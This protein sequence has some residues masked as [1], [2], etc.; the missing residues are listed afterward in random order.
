MSTLY[1]HIGGPKTGSTYLQSIFRTNREILLEHDIFYPDGKEKLSIGPTS[2]TSGNGGDI[3]KSEDNFD[4]AM[5][6]IEA[7]PGKSLF[8]SHEG[9]RKDFAT[10]DL[11]GLIPE[12]ARSKGF[13]HIKILFLVRNPV[14][15]AVS[16]WQQLVKNNGCHDELEDLVKNTP[17]MSNNYIF[18]RDI[19]KKLSKDDRFELSVFNYSRCSDNLSGLTMQWLGIPEEKI[20][21]PEATRINRSLTRAELVLQM[22]MNRILGGDAKILSKALTENITDIVTEK[23]SLSTEAQLVLWNRLKPAIIEA[24]KYLPSDHEIIFDQ[25]ETTSEIKD[26]YSFSGSQLELIGKVVAEEIRNLRYPYVPPPDSGPKNK[27]S[28]LSRARSLFRF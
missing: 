23:I 20:S 19:L 4:E 15:Y 22:S 13:D 9:M 1:L 6:A 7:Y 14:A 17:F 16:V 18:T 24:N 2:W 27:S 28:I 8:Y 21:F 12:I 26:S 5:K 10:S 11:V 25:Q 3:L